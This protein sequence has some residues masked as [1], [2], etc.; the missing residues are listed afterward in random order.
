MERYCRHEQ[1]AFQ[2]EKQ[3]KQ[4]FISIDLEF[5]QSEPK[6]IKMQTNQEAFV[7]EFPN[8]RLTFQTFF[9]KKKYRTMNYQETPLI[10]PETRNQFSLCFEWKS[11]RLVCLSAKARSVL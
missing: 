7:S 11:P 8:A 6:S 1:L 5:Q 9:A 3:N 4:F 2:Q 10:R